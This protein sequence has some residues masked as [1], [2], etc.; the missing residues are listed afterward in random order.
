MEKAGLDIK[1]VKPI[2]LVQQINIPAL[3]ISGKYD[4]IIPPS[5]IRDLFQNYGG[6]PKTLEIID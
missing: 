5:Q 1:D 2:L 6:T 4:K 3:F